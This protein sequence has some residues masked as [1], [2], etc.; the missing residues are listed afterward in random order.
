MSLGWDPD[1]VI[2]VIDRLEKEYGESA[3][4]IIEEAL[5]FS[6]QE[7]GK[8]IRKKDEPEINPKKFVE[9]F[10]NNPHEE[11]EFVVESDKKATIITKKC[12]IAEVF[13]EL[14]NL[15][16]GF[17]F[18]CAQDYYIAKGYDEGMELEIKKCLMKGDHCC[19][20]QY[21]KVK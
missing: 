2:A 7:W 13:K 8:K 5:A 21:T 9:H 20:H 18:K 10:K 15:E 19:I 3:L 11:M 1:D 6:A 17:R 12:R 16:K 4:K 14:N